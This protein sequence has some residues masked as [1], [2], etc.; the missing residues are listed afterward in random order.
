M[1]DLE[2]YELPSALLVNGERVPV[3]TSFRVWLRFARILE[4]ERLLWHG[5]F[6]GGEPPESHEWIPAALE[7][8]QSPNAT[9]KEQADSQDRLLSLSLDGELIVAAFQQAYGIDLT[10]GDMHW[11]RFKALLGGLPAETMLARV[12]SY[13]GWE[14]PRSQSQD[15]RDAQMRKLKDAWTLPDPRREAEERAVLD[16]FERWAAESGVVE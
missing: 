12:M 5:I 10:E 2:R 8:L 11:H 3:L 9:P 6:P 7:F 1:I 16:A 14:K 15:A 13:R 4:D